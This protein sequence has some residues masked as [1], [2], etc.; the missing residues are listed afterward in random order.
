MSERIKNRRFAVNGVVTSAL[1]ACD[2]ACGLVCPINSAHRPATASLYG[3][4]GDW[5]AGGQTFVYY[6]SSLERFVLPFETPLLDEVLSR[7][8]FFSGSAL[9]FCRRSSFSLNRRSTSSEMS[10]F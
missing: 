4:S 3:A 2:A 8:L 6:T 7:F 5:L 10:S 9:N 1:C